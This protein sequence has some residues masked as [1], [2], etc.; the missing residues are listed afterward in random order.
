MRKRPKLPFLPTFNPR[1]KETIDII[2]VALCQNM[3]EQMEKGRPGPTILD[4]DTIYRNLQNGRM[5]I[6]MM[7]GNPAYPEVRFCP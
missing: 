2:I 5:V 6:A 1:N 4:Y 3:K 7:H